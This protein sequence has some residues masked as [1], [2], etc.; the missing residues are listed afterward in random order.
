M[1]GARTRRQA[2]AEDGRAFFTI[3]VGLMLALLV[4]GIIEGFVTRQPWPWPLKI[5]IGTVA[6]LLFLAYQWIVGRRAKK[7]GETGDVADFEAG[8]KA[9][10]AA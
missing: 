7:A 10:V 8:A 2:L 5:G 4:S 9:I 1:P 3:V 6:L